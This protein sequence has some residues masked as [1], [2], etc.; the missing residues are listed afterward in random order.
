MKIIFQ[1]RR[2]ILKLVREAMSSGSKSREIPEALSQAPS[3]DEPVY[4]GGD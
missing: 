1:N 2:T 3:L 4:R